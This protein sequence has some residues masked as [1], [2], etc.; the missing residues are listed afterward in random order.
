MPLGTNHNSATTLA[1]FIPEIWGQSINEYFR[2]E[3]KFASFFTDR[4][5]ELMDGGDT[6]HTPN[7]TAMTANLK[8][9]GYEVTL[10][11]TTEGSVDLVVSTHYEVSF[12]IEDKEV[13]QMKRSYNLQNQKAKDA[14]YEAASTLES[15][16]AQLFKGFSGYVGSTTTNVSDADILAAIATLASNKV[17]GMKQDGTP[18]QDVNFIFHPN[19]WYR[20]VCAIDRFALAQNSPGNNPAGS[21][22]MFS[23]YGIPAIVSANVPYNSGSAGRVNVLAHR[24]AIHWAKSPLP[25]TP[26]SFTGTEGVRVQTNYIPQYLGWLTTSD[27]LFGCIENR[28]NAAIRILSHETKAA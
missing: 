10:N 25:P 14:G 3:L 24:D 7:V 9:P 27:I 22:P 19:T 26:G 4:S 15:A 6:L 20:Q 28:D 23:V 8:V 1:P 11:N 13:A 17:T 2:E 16:I 18:G 5:E 12:L 21:R